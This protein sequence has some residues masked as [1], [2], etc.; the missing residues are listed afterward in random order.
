MPFYKQ[1][2]LTFPEVFLQAYL[3][4]DKAVSVNSGHG[5]YAP[6]SVG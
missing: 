4:V 5:A 1:I 3:S 6:G 2:K